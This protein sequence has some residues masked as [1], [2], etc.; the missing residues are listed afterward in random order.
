MSSQP[1]PPPPT[2]DQTQTFPSI[3]GNLYRYVG[4]TSIAIWVTDT[5]KFTYC[6]NP[7]DIFV[8]M[9]LDLGDEDDLFLSQLVDIQVTIVG[10]GVTAWIMVTDIAWMDQQCE[11]VE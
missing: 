5:H 6:L 11:L 7:N 2:S 9:A 1:T 3:V 4:D 8:V 10:S